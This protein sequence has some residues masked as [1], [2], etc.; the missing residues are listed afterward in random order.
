VH[1]TSDSIATLYRPFRA[2][3]FL[4]VPGVETRVKPQAECFNPFGIP[5]VHRRF[6]NNAN[7]VPLSGH[8][9][10]LYLTQG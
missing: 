2:D 1:V 4:S 7:L 5:S 6:T 10:Y 8:I 9:S 3:H